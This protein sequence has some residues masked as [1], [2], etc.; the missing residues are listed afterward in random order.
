MRTIRTRF[1]RAGKLWGLRIPKA[2]IDQLNLGGGV[3]IAVH[4]DRL[5]IQ[6]ASRRRE[7]WEEEFRKMA[8]RGDDALLDPYQPTEWEKTQWKW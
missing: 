6:S 4:G 7:G 1:I 3:E 2:L 5:V 8:E